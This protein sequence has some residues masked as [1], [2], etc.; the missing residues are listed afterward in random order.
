MLV[1]MTYFIN[2]KFFAIIVNRI[3]II[4]QIGGLHSFKKSISA[5]GGYFLLL[6]MIKIKIL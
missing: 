5:L 4:L 2:S 6:S 3:E 1:V